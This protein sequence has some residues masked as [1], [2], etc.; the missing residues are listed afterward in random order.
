VPTNGESGRRRRKV[1]LSILV[2]GTV[3]V[4]LIEWMIYWIG[5]LFGFFMGSAH[6][7]RWASQV[8]AAMIGLSL[9]APVVLAAHGW[10]RRFRPLFL[11]FVLLYGAMLVGLWYT[12]P[13]IWGPERCTL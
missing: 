3:A 7:G 9:L 8:W 11:G 4:G 12:S 13:T 5:D 10:R 6:G 1:A 2:F